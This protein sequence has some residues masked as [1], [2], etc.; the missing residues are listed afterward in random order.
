MRIEGA[1]PGTPSNDPL[2]I[3]EAFA[4]HVSTAL[5]HEFSVFGNAFST[6][7][8]LI[9]PKLA[10]EGV[11]PMIEFA[12]LA[13]TLAKEA[14]GYFKEGK[15]VFDALKGAADT[16][17]DIKEHYQL[18]DADPRLVDFQWPEKSGFMKRAEADGYTIRWSQ[19]DKVVSRELDGYEVM[20][21]VDEKERTRRK[22][23][24]RD[25][26]VLIGKKN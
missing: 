19:P 6:A 7:H 18:K 9:H 25:G 21:E 4:Q 5:R 24:L 3:L 11:G 16:A 20:Y 17:K 12:G 13:Y 8:D 2:D 26:L 22:L 1:K 14:F 23:V 15:E 10:R